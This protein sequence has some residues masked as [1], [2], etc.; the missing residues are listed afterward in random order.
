MSIVHANAELNGTPSSFASTDTSGHSLYSSDSGNETVRTSPQKP[1]LNLK[2][3]A[4]VP[5][6]AL[7]CFCLESVQYSFAGEEIITLSCGH[8]VHFDC[9]VELYHENDT[10]TLDSKLPNEN[11][12][13]LCPQ[14]NSKV[15]CDSNDLRLKLLQADLLNVTGDI[16]QQ[17]NNSNL[18]ACIQTPIG[19]HIM[20]PIT[21][22][23]SSP[24]FSIP[25]RTPESQIGEQF[26]ARSVTPEVDSGASTANTTDIS[27]SVS[28]LATEPLFSNKV[29]PPL[30]SPSTTGSSAIFD[31]TQLAKISLIPG[32]SHIMVD[33]LQSDKNSV[34]S[35]VLNV[36]AA[37]F[38]PAPIS[39]NEE[40]QT[41]THIN[42]GKVMDT[43]LTVFEQKLTP[44]SC[45]KLDVANWGSLVIFDYMK[46]VTYNGENFNDPLIFLFESALVILDSQVS[47][48]LLMEKLDDQDRISSVY[49]DEVSDSLVL[50]ITSLQLSEIAFET[51]GKVMLRKW[52]KVFRLFRL[53]GKSSLSNHSDCVESKVL[54][55]SEF[56]P[57]VQVST[58]AWGLLPDASECIPGKIKKINKLQSKGL[59]LPFD[60][61]SKKLSRPD[62]I[63]LNLILVLP[64][65]QYSDAEL[66]TTDFLLQMKD[67]ILSVFNMLRKE[68]KIGLVFSEMANVEEN[69]LGTYYG[70]APKKWPGWKKTL[71]LLNENCIS[72]KEKRSNN[73]WKR[74]LCSVEI[75]SSLGFKKSKN[76]V[77]QVIFVTTEPIRRGLQHDTKSLYPVKKC[78]K[79]VQMSEV[80]HQLCNKFDASFTTILL[81]DEFQFN[82]AELLQAHS[83][84]I[85]SDRNDEISNLITE[86][87]S[88]D[89]KDLQVTIRSLL[90]QLNNIIIRNMHI[91]L[92]VPSGVKLV[93]FEQEG[94]L[95]PYYEDA[96]SI[97][98]EDVNSSF[99]KTFMFR[100]ELDPKKLNPNILE[101][102]GKISL[103]VA[104]A[105]M[106]ANE[107][108]S[109]APVVSSLDIR[110]QPKEDE[111]ARVIAQ[112]P[113]SLKISSD[114]N[115]VEVPIVSSPPVLNSIFFKRKIQLLIHE[116]LWENI[117]SVADFDQETK[118]KIR[119]SIKKLNE[120]IWKLG[121]TAGNENGGQISDWIHSI[122]AK[123]TEIGEGYS[124]RD[125]E[126]SNYKALGYYLAG[127]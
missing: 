47:D 106:M 109:G 105:D 104:K 59:V 42:K 99:S 69:E 1:R 35:A 92:K 76:V 10:Y 52:A 87:L 63:P 5:A 44:Q 97:N 117:L 58:N 4:E 54:Q 16:A 70:L 40:E 78:K 6:K 20:S 24:A 82:I 122:Q 53:K 75:L 98:L 86:Y 18:P 2:K 14:C 115:D 88:L 61:Q 120:Q 39:Q 100:V 30:N 36:K 48:I 68:D 108:E 110:I 119:V 103:A 72:K 74:G 77:N 84:M 26:W 101:K 126:L 15:T 125:Y 21:T 111:V 95:E 19:T 71:D 28:I 62:R 13:V 107:L 65:V 121:N 22:F 9:F 96:I 89:P 56:I 114:A 67:V 124:M 27:S 31:H 80:V 55:I 25:I 85:R 12:K 8:F 73:Q 123:L 94:K 60:Y 118:S 7:C 23:A 83:I 49:V 66:S 17:A 102:G 50:N 34:I 33:D 51:D 57:L 29:A 64:L 46:S 127:I 112:T 113:I 11:L 32:K 41:I 43:V 90:Q 91:S 116:F 81:A 45:E 79:S 37:S 93:S 38:E 3:R